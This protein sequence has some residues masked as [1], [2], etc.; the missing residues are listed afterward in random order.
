MPPELLETARAAGQ[1]AALDRGLAWFGQSIFRSYHEP[2]DAR[3]ALVEKELAAYYVLEEGFL[4]TG[5][6]QEFVLDGIQMNRSDRRRTLENLIVER[7]LTSNLEGDL[8]ERIRDPI[9]STDTRR[10][11]DSGEE[12]ESDQLSLIVNL[13]VPAGFT[14]LLFIALLASTGYLVTGTAVEK[15]NKVV[16]VLLASA[17]PDEVLTGK[18]VGLGAASLLQLGV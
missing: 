9:S 12:V 8:A 13:V 7:L 3:A 1:G 5:E 10:L 17:N 2:A 11:S 15:E 14:I 6:L 18:L 16:E 4:A